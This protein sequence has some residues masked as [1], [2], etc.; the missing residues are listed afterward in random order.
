VAAFIL[1]SKEQGGLF[2]PQSLSGLRCARFG[3]K[4]G[5]RSP[6]FL[7][8]VYGAGAGGPGFLS[9]MTSGN[10]ASVANATTFELS[11]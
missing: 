2:G 10:T 4:R 8:E 6:Q 3:A 1:V 7:T 11:A 5:S 9:R